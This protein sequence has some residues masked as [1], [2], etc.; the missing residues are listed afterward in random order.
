MDGWMDVWMDEWTDGVNV[1][2]VMLVTVA[3]TV[4]VMVMVGVIFLCGQVGSCQLAE[5]RAAAWRAARMAQCLVRGSV[6]YAVRIAQH[7]GASSYVLRN[8]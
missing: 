5:F 3:R 7:I 6:R 2:M 4:T 8:T 1:W